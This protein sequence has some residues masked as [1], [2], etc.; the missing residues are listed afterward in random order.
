MLC[1]HICV[2]AAS[3]WSQLFPVLCQGSPESHQRLARTV[4]WPLSWAGDSFFHGQSGLETT[5]R[6]SSFHSAVWSMPLPGSLLPCRG[7]I[8]SEVN[9]Y[10][11]ATCQLWS[12]LRKTTAICHLAFRP[13]VLP[14]WLFLNLLN[15]FVQLTIKVPFKESWQ[16]HTSHIFPLWFPMWA[17]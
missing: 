14:P 6:E 9:Y 8:G 13:T 3:S 17:Y 1:S 10:M 11:L 16:P 15:I 2:E 5:Q 7:R 4:V 12:A